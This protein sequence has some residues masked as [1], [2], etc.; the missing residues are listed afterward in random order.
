MCTLMTTSDLRATRAR[1][2]LS[3]NA[4][5]SLARRRAQRAALALAFDWGLVATAVF[6]SAQMHS[7][8]VYGVAVLV[9]SRQMNALFELHHHAIHDNLFGT[10]KWNERLDWLYS[11]PLFTRV[12]ED[13]DEHMEHHRSFRVDAKDHLTWGRGYG[14]DPA[15]RTD[16][17][18]MI[19]FLLVRPFIG[20][21][22][23]D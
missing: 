4:L 3:T 21:L 19:W 17:G 20:V 6:A 7:L 13:R 1:P 16:R 18:Y 9:I 10:R 8:W 23:Y 2:F 22:Q 11:I 14:L 5:G 15:R 12:C